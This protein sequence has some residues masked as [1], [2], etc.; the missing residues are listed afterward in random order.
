MCWDKYSDMIYL[1]I[2]FRKVEQIHKMQHLI[3]LKKFAHPVTSENFQN[4][5]I[6]LNF[7]FPTPIYSA[8]LHFCIKSLN[9]WDLN[10]K[11][12]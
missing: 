11:N 3:C 10:L 6:S 9:F 1:F 7:Y 2:F 5:Q 8:F 4:I 12:D